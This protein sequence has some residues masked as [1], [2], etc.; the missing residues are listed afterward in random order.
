M[1]LTFASLLTLLE[2]QL[3]N[4][5]I[6]AQQDDFG[7]RVTTV[8]CFLQG[9]GRTLCKADCMVSSVRASLTFLRPSSWNCTKGTKRAKSKYQSKLKILQE[10]YCN[11]IC[12]SH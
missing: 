10:K 11:Y 2:L 6:D 7:I 8:Y 3:S 5:F 1:I 4:D 9:K 12:Y